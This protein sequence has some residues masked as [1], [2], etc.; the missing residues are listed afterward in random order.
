MTHNLNNQIEE[1]LDIF[2]EPLREVSNQ[3]TY[4]QAYIR[5]PHYSI[6]ENGDN[7]IEIAV[8]GYK[9]D[10]LKVKIKEKNQLF[11]V[12]TFKVENETS[13]F[14]KKIKRN[15]QTNLGSLPDNTEKV[16]YSLTDG[17]LKITIK[18]KQI[19][20]NEILVEKE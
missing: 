19:K 9:E 14:R 8:P 16:T 4:L 15:F 10:E 5:P 6:L 1:F 13:D 2:A 17:I 12:S 18:V 7:I 11:L 3:S 20:E